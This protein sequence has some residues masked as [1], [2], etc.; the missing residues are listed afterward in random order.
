VV[1]TPSHALWLK[2]LP[3]GSPSTSLHVAGTSGVKILSLATPVHLFLALAMAV[4]FKL[5]VSEMLAMAVPF[6]A[7]HI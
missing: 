3:A 5:S 6:L 1:L 2:A 7:L 4:V